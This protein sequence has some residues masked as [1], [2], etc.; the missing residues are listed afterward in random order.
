MFKRRLFVVY[1]VSGLLLAQ[2]CSAQTAAKKKVASQSDL[3]RFS[4]ALTIPASELVQADPATFDPFA[5]RV[6][7]DLD[8]VFRDYD[9]ADKATMRELL[10][11]KMSLQ[12]LAGDFSGALETV[13]A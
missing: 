2:F 11:T 3:P 4:Y 12:E 6:R 10:A 13:R 1:L 7:A 5:A 9:I 8:S